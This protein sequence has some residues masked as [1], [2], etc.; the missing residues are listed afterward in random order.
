M[1]SKHYFVRLLFTYSSAKERQ[2]MLR[3]FVFSFRYSASPTSSYVYPSSTTLDSD[4]MCGRTNPSGWCHCWWKEN[5]H[6]YFMVSSWLSSTSL[7]KWPDGSC[8]C[9][10]K[11]RATI[12][13]RGMLPIFDR[14]PFW[15]DLLTYVM[16]VVSA[17]L[18]DNL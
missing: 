15:L 7:C 2:E 6:N 1:Q 10:I 8:W 3:K 4:Y 5:Y 16:F 9:R 11:V 14:L 18:V 17:L 12:L 13:H